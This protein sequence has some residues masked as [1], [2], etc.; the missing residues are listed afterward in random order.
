MQLLPIGTVIICNQIPLM[1]LGYTA[2]KGLDEVK[3]CY[4][5][6]SYPA[7]FVKMNKIMFI[8]VSGE[9]SVLAEGFLD[10]K[11]REVLQVVG[12]AL[13]SVREDPGQVY[14]ILEQAQI[15]LKSC[16]KEQSYE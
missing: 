14:K 2:Y 6:V 4:E 13:Q 16:R 3:A 12:T 11:N 15:D 10:H 1:I 5:V 9:F 8:P 7:G